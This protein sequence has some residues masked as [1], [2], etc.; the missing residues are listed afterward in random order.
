MFVKTNKLNLDAIARTCEPA[1]VKQ[2]NS[3]QSTR[4]SLSEKPSGRRRRRARRRPLALQIR[5]IPMAV[6]G[7]PNPE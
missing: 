7:P 6:A 2:D 4:N 3:G 5:G 1:V